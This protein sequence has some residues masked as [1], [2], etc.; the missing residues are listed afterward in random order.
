MTSPL[1]SMTSGSP[2]LRRWL[3]IV[4]LILMPL[5][6]SWAAMLEYVEHFI[7]ADSAEA[8]LFHTHHYHDAKHGHGLDGALNQP[9]AGGLSHTAGLDEG[10]IGHIHL[11]HAAFMATALALPLDGPACDRIGFEL[12]A[13]PSISPRRLDRPPLFARR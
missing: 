9:D 5:Q 12:H 8:A 13:Y 11:G 2:L 1:H 7:G 4:L 3:A 10:D 6:G